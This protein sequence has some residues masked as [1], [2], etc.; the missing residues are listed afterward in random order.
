MYVYI[1]P[2]LDQTFNCDIIYVY[3]WLVT[4]IKG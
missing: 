3:L 2:F 4:F 1:M